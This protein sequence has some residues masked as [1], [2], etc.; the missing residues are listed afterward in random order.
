MSPLKRIV[1]HVAG[2]SSVVG[3]VVV[4]GPIVIYLVFGLIAVLALTGTFGSPRCQEAAQVVLAILLGRTL[5]QG[6]GTRP[7]EARNGRYARLQSGGG[8]VA[9]VTK[10]GG[11]SRRGRQDRRPRS[12]RPLPSPDPA[13]AV[14]P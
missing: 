10:D 2:V 1:W 3:A 5:P 4:S 14:R 8:D 9:V 11:T 7:D 6:V 12:S 13:D